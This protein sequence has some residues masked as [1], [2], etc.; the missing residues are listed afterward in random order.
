MARTVP[1]VQL[2]PS[3][4]PII[5][6]FDD[7]VFSGGGDPGSKEGNSRHPGGHARVL[8]GCG[9]GQGYCKVRKVLLKNWGEGCC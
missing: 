2:A 8:V 7:G 6:L 3:C 4:F 1:D 9:N 5:G